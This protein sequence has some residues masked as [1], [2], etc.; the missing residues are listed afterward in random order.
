MECS[1]QDFVEAVREIVVSFKLAAF[2]AQAVGDL[3]R[4]LFLK[5]ASYGGLRDALNGRW[6]AQE[7]RSLRAEAISFRNKGD[8][9]K[10]FT[11]LANFSSLKPGWDSYRAEPPLAATIRAAEGFLMFLRKKGTSP[12]K[13]N[14][15]VVGGVGFSFRNGPRAVYI[16]FRNTG[17][18]HAAFTDDASEPE[19]V[20]VR[21]DTTGYSEVV[22][23]AEEYLHEQTARRD[24]NQRPSA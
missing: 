8:W 4:P 11:K 16:E 9:E 23:R 20:K 19:V 21:Q 3:T 7:L 14:P 15:S 6:V 22:A 10:W 13:I 5:A 18:A 24:E 2:K 1:G 12:T 17:N